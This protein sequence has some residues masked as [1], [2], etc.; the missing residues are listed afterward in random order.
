MTPD[1]QETDR[2]Q[3]PILRRVRPAVGR[4]LVGAARRRFTDPSRVQAL[5]DRYDPHV[6]RLEP[7]SR[8]VAVSECTG[9]V[10]DLIVRCRFDTGHSVI[11]K[12]FL[13][14]LKEKPT[15]G[16]RGLDDRGRGIDERMERFG[17]QLPEGRLRVPEAYA[18]DGEHRVLWMEDVGHGLSPLTSDRWHEY[19]SEL[20]RGLAVVHAHEPARAEVERMED[21]LR[22]SYLID[23]P[24]R[25]LEPYLVSA[26]RRR[27][28]DRFR[29]ID[30]AGRRALIHGDLA[31]KNVMIDAENRLWLLDFERSNIASPAYDVG[32]CY[33][34]LLIE[35]WDRHPA[36]F[37]PSVFLTSYLQT[38]SVPHDFIL[39]VRHYAALTVAYRL[40]TLA[41]I[42]TSRPDL[43]T[44]MERKLRVLLDV[45]H[46]RDA[47]LEAAG[48]SSDLVL[49]RD[50]GRRT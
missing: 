36:F 30:A 28:W 41:F 29:E 37:D 4:R 40:N 2:A 48:L 1:V 14:V 3:D 33:A 27:R 32:L 20:G 16:F 6:F 24:Y 49:V 25:F 5:F 18:Y 45:E 10:A 35:Q 44:A 31:P 39:L 34:H 15:V 42:R 38:A 7:G 22:R 21:A 43:R 12:V 8:L 50:N 13:P 26:S 46:P 11:G 17:A 9:N 19:L 47:L 23:V